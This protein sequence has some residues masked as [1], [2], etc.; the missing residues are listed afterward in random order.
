MRVEV[1]W[2]TLSF[3]YCGKEELRGEKLIFGKWE[4][5]VFH[6]EYV[7]FSSSFSSGNPVRVFASINHGNESFTVHDTAFVWVEDVTTSRFKAC[8][9][10]GGRGAGGY[11]TID[12]FAFQGSQSGVYHG[13]TSFSL[14]TTGTQC[15]Q[16]AFPQA[17]SLVPKV[18]VTVQHA[19][20]DQ[21]QD[22]MSIWMENVTTRQFEVCLRESRAFDGAH[23]N[24]V[25]VCENLLF[26][27]ID[28]N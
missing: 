17:F 4:T 20:L 3:M 9:V 14:F 11:T 10:Q 6:C 23:N 22:A 28:P 27:L 21:R 19:T 16:V 26:V 13:E 8:L 15:S 5:I 1:K 7:S 2:A 24:L 18:H 12:W 25:V